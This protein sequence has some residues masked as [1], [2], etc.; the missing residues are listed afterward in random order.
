ML[1]SGDTAQM[2]TLY[3]TFLNASE[4]INTLVGTLNGPVTSTT[5][6]GPAADRFRMQ[7]VDEFAPMLVRLKQSLETNGTIVQQRRAALEQASA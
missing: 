3:A 7:W 6:T 4:E 2:D 5:W 1:L